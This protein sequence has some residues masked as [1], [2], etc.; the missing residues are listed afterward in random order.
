MCTNTVES[1]DIVGSA[2]GSRGWMPVDRARIAYDHP[3][4]APLEHAV[5]IDLVV[6][7]GEPGDRVALELSADSARALGHAITRAL[8]RI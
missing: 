2:K 4:N 3:F 7:T 1:I 6:S 8:T 5:T